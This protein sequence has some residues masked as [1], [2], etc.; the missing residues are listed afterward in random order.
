MKTWRRGRKPATPEQIKEAKEWQKIRVK[1][2]NIVAR[3][4]TIEKK[5]CIC[6][7]E[8]AQILHN[9]KDPYNIAFICSEC[10]KDKK[11]LEEAEKHRFSL[12]EYKQEQLDNRDDNRYL[13]TRKFSQ[14][15]VKEIID[16]YIAP[17]NTLTMG[18]YAEE[19]N[20]SRYQFN[21]L[22][23]LYSEYFHKRSIGKVVTNRSKTIQ[24]LKL[25]AAA[26]DRN[27]V[28]QEKKLLSE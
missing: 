20:I 9:K 4:E 28:K 26:N 12:E 13:D 18:E 22:V 17:S 14:E 15:E 25:S 24:K 2:T 1:I 7:K 19:H 10:R 23:D 6:G 3:D 11:N 8:D 16:G 27:L 21:Q 5:C